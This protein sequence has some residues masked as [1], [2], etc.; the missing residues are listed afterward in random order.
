[1]NISDIYRKICIV[2]SNFNNKLIRGD[3]KNIANKRFGKTFVKA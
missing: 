2:F 3:K 1:M